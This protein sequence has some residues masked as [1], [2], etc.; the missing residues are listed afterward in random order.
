MIK[1]LS[2]LV[3][4]ARQHCQS[5]DIEEALQQIDTKPSPLLVDVREPGETQNHSVKGAIN[6]P[7]GVLEMKMAALCHDPDQPILIYCA[8]GGRASLSAVA[9][10]KM[11]YRNVKVIQGDCE[12]IANSMN[13][14]L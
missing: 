7:R 13:R 11:G 2:E 1:P 10:Q 4:E 12:L 6:I 3:A 14:D 5:I 8:T 9:L